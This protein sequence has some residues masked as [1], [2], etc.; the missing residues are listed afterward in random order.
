MCSRSEHTL[1]GK[2]MAVCHIGYFVHTSHLKCIH[3]IYDTSFLTAG[4][5][6]HD[7]STKIMTQCYLSLCFLV[8]IWL[9]VLTFSWKGLWL[10]GVA[11]KGH[12][13]QP[14]YHDDS[15]ALQPRGRRNLIVWLHKP[16]GSPV[17]GRWTDRWADK[18]GEKD[19]HT[20]SS[21]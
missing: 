12:L 13:S 2:L 9:M 3:T 5:H 7:S 18:Q 16:P 20:D 17:G 4:L 21:G 1:K 10:A 11:G 6:G 19:R 14:S 15:S 8:V